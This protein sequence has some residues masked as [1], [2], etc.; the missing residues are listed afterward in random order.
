MGEDRL[1]LPSKVKVDETSAADGP[2][3]VGGLAKV[4]GSEAGDSPF[5]QVLVDNA[6]LR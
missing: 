4:D 2:D 5:R 1:V 6:R 3:V